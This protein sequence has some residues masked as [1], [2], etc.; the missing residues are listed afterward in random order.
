MN[1]SKYVVFLVLVLLSTSVV[2]QKV[3]KVERVKE[4]CSVKNDSRQFQWKLYRYEDGT[5]AA[6]TTNDERITPNVFIRPFYVGGGLFRVATKEKNE[7]GNIVIT[8]YDEHGEKVISESLSCIDVFHNGDGIIKLSKKNKSDA[9]I[10]AVFDRKGKAIVPFNKGYAYV[11]YYPTQ[12]RILC[13]DERGADYVYGLDGNERAKGS[14]NTGAASEADFTNMMSNKDTV[15][16]LSFGS[17]RWTKVLRGGWATLYGESDALL[18]PLSRGY[19]DIQ[20]VSVKGHIGYFKTMRNGRVGVCDVYGNEV[21]PPVYKQVGYS[22]AKGFSY[23]DANYLSIWLDVNGMP[24]ESEYQ[25]MV[26]VYV[27]GAP[28]ARRTLAI[29]PVMPQ[30]GKLIKFTRYSEDDVVWTDRI[31]K[32]NQYTDIRIRRD[33][34]YYSHG[35]TVNYISYLVFKGRNLGVLEF[36]K[37]KRIISPD[38]G[39][40]N[41][42]AIMATNNAGNNIRCYLVQKGELYGACDERGKEIIAPAYK[43]LAYDEDGGFETR[44]STGRWQSI[45]V[46]FTSSGRLY[47][48]TSGNLYNK[49]LKAADEALEE[50]RYVSAINS[51]AEALRYDQSAYAYYNYGVALYN[52]GDYRKARG[53]FGKAYWAAESEDNKDL[54]NAALRLKG[55]SDDM[56][57]QRSQERWAAVAEVGLYALGVTAAVMAASAAAAPTYGTPSYGSPTYGMPTYGMPTYQMGDGADAAIANAN[58]IMQQ[59]TD[60]MQYELATM[61]QLMMQQTQMQM[62]AQEAAKEAQWMQDYENYKR[63]PGLLLNS[64]GS[65]LTWEQYKQ[66]RRQ[67]EAQAWAES[68]QQESVASQMSDNQV[69]RSEGKRFRPHVT[70]SD[71]PHCDIPGNG[72]CKTCGGDGLMDSSFGLGCNNLECSSCYSN[73]KGKCPFCHGTGK[74]IKR[75]MEYE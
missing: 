2:A 1:K 38:R 56:V 15:M 55:Q 58:R 48:S 72:K 17:Y 42:T 50:E 12:Q 10:W 36:P 19:N 5:C 14:G 61:P 7:F 4:E 75:S 28:K 22:L 57:K 16:A 3:V 44:T 18:I 46:Y 31:S 30:R 35:D 34:P 40:T 21:L 71:C 68:Q 69:E 54:A 26:S 51:Y 37:A 25:D 63:N 59:S 8:V 29:F 23:D 9:A 64:D 53:T 49:N 65:P 47:K 11:T 13:K 60:R 66:W 62:A 39:Y 74:K 43:S 67:V 20:F 24:C 32:S 45:G 73:Q 41:I 33:G 6:F 52:N 70:E 27:K